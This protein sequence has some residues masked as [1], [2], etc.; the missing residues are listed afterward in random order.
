MAKLVKE[1]RSED[2]RTQARH[3]VKTYILLPSG[4]LGLLCMLGGMGTLGYQLVASGTYTGTTFITSVALLLLGGVC[5]WLQT[6]YHRY[7]FETVPQVFA[8]R[9]RSAVQRTHKKAKPEPVIPSIDHQGR[10]LVPV[11]YVAGIGLLLGSSLWAITD[12]SMD[13]IAALLMPWA[14]FYW[15]K[16]FFWRGIVS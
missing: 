10:K 12:G 9:M 8:A 5:G 16:L 15:S 7:L 14:G 4:F 6:R 1:W 13:A 11:A 3:Y 2:I